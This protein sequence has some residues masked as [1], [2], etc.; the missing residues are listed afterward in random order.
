MHEQ[1]TYERI[2][3]DDAQPNNVMVN[4][5]PLLFDMHGQSRKKCLK[6]ADAL[7]KSIAKKEFKTFPVDSFKCF[8]LL[9]TIMKIEAQRWYCANRIFWLGGLV[10]MM[11]A[12]KLPHFTN[13]NYV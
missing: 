9:T 6:A 7:R 8:H 13:I 11:R 2:S 4:Y 10:D 12:L 5:V 1:L 3:C